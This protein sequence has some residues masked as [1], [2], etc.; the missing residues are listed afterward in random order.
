[1]KIFLLNFFLLFAALT[2]I[3]KTDAQAPANDDCHNAIDVGTGCSTPQSASTAGATPSLFPSSCSSDADDDIWYTFTATSTSVT[4]SVSNAVLES[5]GTA[6]IGVEVYNGVCYDFGSV[7]CDSVMASGD[8]Q[9]TI[10]NLNVGSKY[11]IRF[12]TAG[13][14]TGGSFNFC[15][16]DLVIVPVQLSAYYISCIEGTSVIHWTTTSEI[17]NHFFT[18]ERSND[19]LHFETLSTVNASAGVNNSNKYLVKDFHPFSTISWY[20]L[21]QT[22][23]DGRETYFKILTSSC[24]SIQDQIMLAPNPVT[25]Q[26]QVLFNGNVKPRQI[27]IISSAGVLVKSVSNPVTQSGKL[28]VETTGIKAG[29]YALQVI[30]QDGTIK[31]VRFIKE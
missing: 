25:D 31:T 13:T 27:N 12:W 2:T 29:V 16:Q 7:F 18:V 21:K 19:G 6:D 14:G 3:E 30:M 8:G 5:L 1:M 10:S 26:L 15:V 28:N 23:L 22:D 20:R 24:G 11:S 17:N 9:Q 4:I